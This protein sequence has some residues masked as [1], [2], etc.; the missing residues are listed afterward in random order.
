M[1]KRL[2]HKAVAVYARTLF[3]LGES[4]GQLASLRDDLEAVRALFAQTPELSR[5]LRLPSLS[6]EK[7]SSLLKPL[8]AQA[9]DL[10]RRFLRLLEIKGRLALLENVCEEFLRLEEE[11][12]N[13]LRARVVSAFPMTAEQVQHLAQGL[14]ARRPGKTYLLHN[15][16]DASLIAGFR[17]EEDDVVTDASLSHKLNE[18]RQKLAA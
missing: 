13:V 15:E 11:R 9:S 16:V 10:F 18:L 17:V 7:K 14:S 2:S 12:R 6:T 3:E 5:V 1:A 8:A 4:K